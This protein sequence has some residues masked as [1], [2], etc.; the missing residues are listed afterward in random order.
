MFSWIFNFLFFYGSMKKFSQLAKKK[1][2]KIFSLTKKLNYK[3][4]FFFSVE[5]QFGAE[6][7]KEFDVVPRVNK[8]FSEIYSILR[9]F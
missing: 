2:L 3:I 8:R 6:W 7:V 4:S 1:Y 5:N 9:S